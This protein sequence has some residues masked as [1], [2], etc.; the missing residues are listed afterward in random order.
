MAKPTPTSNKAAGMIKVQAI[1][2]PNKQAILT[3]NKR[4]HRR[5]PTEADKNKGAMTTNTVKYSRRVLVDMVSWTAWYFGGRS[6][7]FFSRGQRRGDDAHERPSRTNPG[8]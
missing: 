8:S 1:R 6:I 3:R 7:T 5:L 2:M 4:L